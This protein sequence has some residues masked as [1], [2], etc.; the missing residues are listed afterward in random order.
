M[1]HRLTRPASTPPT[2]P[3]SNFARTYRLLGA[4][5]QAYLS[6][7]ELKR[8]LKLRPDDYS[9]DN[10]RRLERRMD[11]LKNQARECVRPLMRCWL[12]LSQVGAGGGDA[13]SPHLT[14][15]R[16]TDGDLAFVWGDRDKG[17]W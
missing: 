6:Q 5:G 14:C 17:G 3:N 9:R 16:V 10:L 1:R 4:A 12:E 15:T 7:D 8:F 11:E 13:A 2:T